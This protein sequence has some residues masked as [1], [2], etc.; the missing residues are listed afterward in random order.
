LRDELVRRLGNDVVRVFLGGADEGEAMC[1]LALDH[2]LFTGST[3]V[4]RRVYEAAA[5]QMVPVTL[6]LGGKS[7]AILHPSFSVDRFARSI[8]FGKTYSAGQSC[9]APDYAL[10]PRGSEARVERAIEA[11]FRARFPSLASNPDY[12]SLASPARKQ[13]LVRMI[14]EAVSVNF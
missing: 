7:P 1:H 4:G 6:E 11:R 5:R 9:V 2:L 14:D 12:S 8:V 13:R 3:A 10:I